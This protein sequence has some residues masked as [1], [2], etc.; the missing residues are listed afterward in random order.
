VEGP[1]T[2]VDRSAELKSGEFWDKATNAILMALEA[3]TLAK[4]AQEQKAIQE[5]NSYVI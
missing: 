1:V 3:F 2:L 5:S 4:I